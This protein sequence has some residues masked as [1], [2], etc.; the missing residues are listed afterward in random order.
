MAV[1]E[2]MKHQADHRRGLRRNIRSGT[3][4][5]FSL[6]HLQGNL[7]KKKVDRLCVYC[8]IKR[9]MAEWILG[10]GIE[11]YFCRRSK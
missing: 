1:R 4:S 10:R 11:E 7:G 6:L 8:D 5:T 2:A 3:P 9:E